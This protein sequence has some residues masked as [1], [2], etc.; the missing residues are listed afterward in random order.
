[1]EVRVP[2]SSTKARRSGSI[3]R[4]PLRQRALSS[5]SSRSEA[6]RDFFERQPQA[7]EGPAHRGAVETPT[8]SASSKSSQCSASVRSGLAL[9]WA[10]SDAP[11]AA[12]LRA[13]APGT[14]LASTAPVSRRSLSSV[15]W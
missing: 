15:V 2:H 1:M 12:P 4:A 13:G 6:G 14:G 3:C 8:P 10:G 9:A 5:S 7:R 11:K